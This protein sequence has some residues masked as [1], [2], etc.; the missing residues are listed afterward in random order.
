MFHS[1][2]VG[3]IDRVTNGKILKWAELTGG[4]NDVGLTKIVEINACDSICR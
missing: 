2:G 1:D 4:E 3:S